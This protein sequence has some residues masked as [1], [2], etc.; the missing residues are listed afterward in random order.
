MARFYAKISPFLEWRVYD[1]TEPGVGKNHKLV[2]YGLTE[3]EARQTVEKLNSLPSE[4]AREMMNDS[5]KRWNSG[6]KFIEV[7]T[8]D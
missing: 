7:P 1:S 3:D 6:E 5:I 2:R 4:K 8:K